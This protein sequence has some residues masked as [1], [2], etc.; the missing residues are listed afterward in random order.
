VRDK[1]M[2]YRTLVNRDRRAA[3]RPQQQLHHCS[4]QRGASFLIHTVPRSFSRCPLH[5]PFTHSATTRPPSL[6]V[7]K[8]AA[9]D[10]QN[11]L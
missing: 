3:A 2:Y 5:R 9:I 6:F 10:E 8:P 1:S 4:V 7:K 11:Y